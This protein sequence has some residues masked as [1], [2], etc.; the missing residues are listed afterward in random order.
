MMAQGNLLPRVVAALT[1]ACVPAR[2]TPQVLDDLADDYADALATRGRG[3]ARLWLVRETLS[4]LL[5]YGTFR[6]R[7]LLRSWRWLVRDLQQAS[8][9]IRRRPFGSFAAVAMLACGLSSVAF[10][11]GLVDAL[12]LRPISKEHGA[13]LNRLAHLDRNGRVGSTFSYVELQQM[14]DQLEPAS[15]LAAVNLEPVMLRAGNMPVQTLGEVV[16][17]S[18]ARLSA[19]DIIAGRGLRP[20]DDEPGA[21]PVAVLGETFWRNRLASTSSVVGSSVVLNMT[22]VTVVG[23]TRARASIAYFGASVD[24]WIVSE[25]ADAMLNRGWRTDPEDRSWIAMAISTPDAASGFPT[26]L[27][28]AASALSHARPE[29]WRDRRLIARPG[30]LLAGSQRGPAVALA[31]VLGALAA[32]ILAIAVAN[33]S[34]LI[35]ARAA[36]DSRQA[37]MHLVLGAGRAALVRRRLAEGTFLGIVAGLLALGL[38]AWARV[39]VAEIS[40]QPNLTLR[41]DLPFDAPL[42][43]MVL[44]AGAGCGIILALAPAIWAMRLDMAAQLR[45]GTVRAGNALLPGVRRALVSAQVA[46]SL[47]LVV[48]AALFARS[49]DA[50]ASADAGFSRHG[51]VAMD[52]DIEP[53]SGIVDSVSLAR[54]ALERVR[55]TPGITHASMASRAPVDPST[56]F[57]SVRRPGDQAP[58]ADSTYLEITDG[59]FD[60]VG[61]RLVRGRDFTALDPAD[62]SVAIVNENLAARLWPGEDPL[63][64]SL[65]IDHLGKTAQVVGV[66]RNAKYRSLTESGAYHVYVPSE[67]K[68]GLALLARSATEPRRM[69]AALQARLDQVGPGVVG[70]FPRTIDDHLSLELLPGRAAAASAT[71]LG[72][73]ALLLSTAGLYG[74]V[75]WFVEVRRQEIGVRMALGA[76]RSSVGRLI[77]GQAVRAAAPGVV[78]GFVL[79]AVLAYGARA[80][81][82]GVS[83]IDPVSFIAGLVAVTLIVAL[84]S[85]VPCRQATRIDPAIALK[86]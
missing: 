27:A 71:A 37:A 6:L 73:V 86:E 74:L 30:L 41:V 1:R 53:A 31:S 78:V 3:A 5:S 45:R 52:F 75:A 85:F 58:A 15:T 2:S 65:V 70:F 81:I 68:F 55:T 9:S 42:G 20:S 49:L 56:P 36:I 69:L 63:G 43:A 8:R 34:G 83:T 11:A 38:Y 67:A 61:L 79:C 64:R 44:L 40:L 29:I 23:I 21:P 4:L 84:A 80:V 66:A 77:V 10:T 54:E 24:V 32:L 33:A 76:S 72:F 14:A 82:A 62:G 35:L 22:P 18:Y 28:S 13:N 50:L 19:A 51:L 26:R 17:P 12:L 46:L 39:G 48:G 59:F 7:R 47:A 60:T 57:S 25:A 16:T